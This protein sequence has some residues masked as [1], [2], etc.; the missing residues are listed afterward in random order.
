VKHP[1]GF[2]PPHSRPAKK[3]LC[4]VALSVLTV[5][6]PALAQT[7]SEKA[8]SAQALF[9]EG[10]RLMGA[11]E[12]AAA[13]PKLAAS[14]KLDPGMGTKFRLADCYEKL[15]KTASAWALFI[16]LGYE[17][18]AAKRLDREEVARKRAAELAPKLVRM[19]IIV[20]PESAK[21]ANL[22]VQRDGTALDKAVWGVPLP[23]DPGEHGLTATA[24]GKKAWESKI[25]V[26]LPSKTVEVTVPAL[27]DQPKVLITKALEPEP[28][29][30]E[31]RS[32]V[33][34]VVLGGVAV[35]AAGVGGALFAVSKGK[36][37]DARD[38][39]LKINDGRCIR[40]PGTNTDAA[41]VTLIDTAN[42]A[43]T[44]HN[45]AIGMFV[46]AGV[47]GAAAVVYLLLPPPAAKKA[48]IQGFRATPIV[49]SGQAG[50][51]LS[52]AF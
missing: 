31:K 28:S 24:P 35:V 39:A 43:D 8:A 6:S 4:A 9:D 3:V 17:A 34:A 45:A 10:L 49:G 23:V 41:C 30:I 14:Q 21:L 27:E 48:S 2:E 44:L 33:P 15:G 40:P 36:E 16:D 51:L 46:G 7:S 22:E 13:C 52:G 29:V 5:S 42:S 50:F 1:G 19:T 20:S 18:R 38:Q 32:L 26:A 47:A 11:G 12:L 25:V 37:S